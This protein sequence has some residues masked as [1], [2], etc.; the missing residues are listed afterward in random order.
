MSEQSF[1]KQGFMTYL[2]E[3]FPSALNNHF[4]YTLV[5]NI[6]DYGIKRQNFTKEQLA[7]FLADVLPEVELNKIERFC[8]DSLLLTKGKVFEVKPPLAKEFIT[9]RVTEWLKEQMSADTNG[10][11]IIHITPEQVGMLDVSDV[12]DLVVY[13]NFN[14]DMAADAYIEDTVKNFFYDSNALIEIQNEMVDDW[15]KRA[16]ETLGNELVFQHM[17]ITALDSPL[18]D[19][20]ERAG[21]KG[22][23]Y[24]ALDFI[25]ET[26]INLLFATATERNYEMG[27]IPAMIAPMVEN[28]N[29]PSEA[30]LEENADN[31][32]VILIHQQGY[33]WA[34]FKGTEGVVNFYNLDCD[35]FLDGGKFQRSVASELEQIDSSGTAT[36]TACVTVNAIQLRDLLDAVGDEQSYVSL[37]T[38]TNIGLFDAQNGGGAM[39]EI[40]LEKPAILP[41]SLIKSIQV[42]Q[43]NGERSGIGR[44]NSDY[45]V[46]SVYGF[47][48]DHWKGS[49]E[50]TKEAPEMV[51]ED[52]SA[53]RKEYVKVLCAK[54]GISPFEMEI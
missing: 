15:R 18:D 23:S 33:K 46:N 53:M 19:I 34:G 52:I 28:T 37:S 22:I 30:V 49:M 11:G 4:T 2:Y 27:L 31:A 17:V 41:A 51:H 47:I 36:L 20:M 29:C 14:T 26:Q 54:D 38:D 32:L 13:R 43:S 21:Y 44:Y 35:D 16:T 12:V 7:M 1:N 8:D 45:A 9:I 50:V 3:Q 24:K 48:N 40:E 42:E 10:T 5:E 39:F 25:G 6:I